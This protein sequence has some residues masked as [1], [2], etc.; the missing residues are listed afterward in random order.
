MVFQN[1]KTHRFPLF[2][3]QVP[4]L[5][6]YALL[7]SPFLIHRFI[8]S[9][10]MTYYIP[11]FL[12]H[13]FLTSTIMTSLHSPLFNT[14]VHDLHNYA[15]LHSHSLFFNTYVHG[16]STNWPYNKTSPFLIQMYIHNFHT[17]LSTKFSTL[18]ISEITMSPK[19]NHQFVSL[20]HTLARSP[21]TN[22]HLEN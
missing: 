9:T 16:L 3:S 17:I 19:F 11:P 14:H 15:L 12:I 22:M 2:N 10:I 6:N 1:K 20:A 13:I 8:T 4:N 5:H 18:K 7:H 21:F